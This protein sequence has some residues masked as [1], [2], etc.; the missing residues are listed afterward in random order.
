MRRILAL[1]ALLPL[2]QVQAVPGFS[3]SGGLNFALPK[4]TEDPGSRSSVW[5]YGLQLGYEFSSG[6][7]VGA[8][9]ITTFPARVKLPADYTALFGNS[10]AVFA[11]RAYICD[12]NLPLFSVGAFSFGASLGAGFANWGKENFASVQ[13]QQH[14]LSGSPVVR[15]GARLSSYSLAYLALVNLELDAIDLVALRASVGYISFGTPIN[16]TAFKSVL[17]GLTFGLGCSLKLW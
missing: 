7:G 12:F 8:R 16:Y 4:G 14:P 15:V 1:L 17:N 10:V 2:F 3:L 11:P 5:T 13:G 9:R 6:F